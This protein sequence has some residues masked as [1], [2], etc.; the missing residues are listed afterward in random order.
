MIAFIIG[1]LIGIWLQL[2][3]T[4]RALLL[5]LTGVQINGST[6]HFGFHDVVLVSSAGSRHRRA[7]A[8]P[9]N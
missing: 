6:K 9:L 8:T 7:T 1:F 4:V 2:A 3:M 5:L